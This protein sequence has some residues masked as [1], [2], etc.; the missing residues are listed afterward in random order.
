MQIQA[1]SV[2]P[3]PR[4]RVF[5]AFRNELPSVAAFMPNIREII[6]V[7]VEDIPGGAKVHNAWIAK[8]DIPKVA[9]S[10]IKPEMLRWDDHAVWDDANT[11]CTWTLKLRVFTDNVRCSGQT[12]LTEEGAGTRV[13]LTGSL[14]LDLRN[15]PGVPRFLAGTIGP[16]VEKF[17]VA[18]VTPNLEQ[19]TSAL[20][21]YLD[22][23]A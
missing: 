23:Q 10:I 14:D 4:A 9:Q 7:A 22:S 5:H 16:Q 21:R 20:S 2:I 15:I 11:R 6:T 17:V 19:M 18:L 8:G 12:I 13:T 3:H 1:S